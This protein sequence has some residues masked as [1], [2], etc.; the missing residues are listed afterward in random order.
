MPMLGSTNRFFEEEEGTESVA[1]GGKSRC[2]VES[3]ERNFGQ[4]TFWE[5]EI[6]QEKGGGIGTLILHSVISL[7]SCFTLLDGDI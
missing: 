1:K 4:K 6:W 7:P 3:E 2:K 5:A